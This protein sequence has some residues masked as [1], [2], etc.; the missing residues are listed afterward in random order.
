MKLL[1]IGSSLITVI[2]FFSCGTPPLRSVS[3]APT[4]NGDWRVYTS[5]DKTFSVELPCEPRQTNVSEPSTPVFQY[6]CHLE[7]SD[8][9]QFFTITVLKADFEVGKIPDEAAFE[10]SVKDIFTPN[11]RIEKIIPIKID[12]GIGREVF[13][14]NTRDD[15]DNIRGRVIAF[16]AHRFEV[17]YLATDLKL[18]E[19]SEADRFFAGFK[20]LK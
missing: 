10:R 6:G 15:M 18:L 7:E 12:G 14:K 9:L 1:S 20:P 16:G 2:G 11:H 5:P 13:V 17:V 8:R 3:S 19:S 4:P